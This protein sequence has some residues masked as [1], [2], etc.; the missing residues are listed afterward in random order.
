MDEG[1][2]GHERGLVPPAYYAPHFRVSSHFAK[3]HVPTGSRR[4][5]G[6]PS[7]M[8]F[9][10][11]FIEEMAHA[12]GKDPYEYRRELIKRHDIVFKE[13]WLTAIDMVAEMSEWGKPL[14]EGWARALSIDDRRANRRHEEVC[15]VVALVS[16]VSVSPAGKVRLERVDIAFDQG[17]GFVNPLSVKKQI[18]GQVYWG[19]DDALYQEMVVK[20][21]RMV[22]NNFDNF[23]VSRMNEYPPKVNIKFFKTNH[24]LEGVGEECLSLLAPTITNAVFKVT[25]K[26]IRSLPLKN[27]DLSWTAQSARKAN[28]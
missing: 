26:R 7:N 20:D 13:D 18:E 21:G 11:S 5:V 4:S 16:T 6:S 8:F 3:F 9:M 22:Q 10:E 28:Q 24:W 27:H 25:G 23:P 1:G 2:G 15:T 19:Y 17:F 14:P 12:A